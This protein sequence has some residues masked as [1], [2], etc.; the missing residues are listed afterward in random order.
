MNIPKAAISQFYNPFF[1]YFFLFL[2][3][4]FCF[5]LYFF[6]FFFLFCFVFL[7]SFLNCCTLRR[8]KACDKLNSLLGFIFFFKKNKL[9]EKKKK[10][11]KAELKEEKHYVK[12]SSSVSNFPLSVQTESERQSLKKGYCSFICNS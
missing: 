7:F 4:L 6:W 1:L 9:R 10:K 5:F 3:V 2:F 8:K 11:R 12:V